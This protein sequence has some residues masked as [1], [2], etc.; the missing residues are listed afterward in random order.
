MA[1]APIPDAFWKANSHHAFATELHFHKKEPLDEA[2]LEPASP[3]LPKM[4]KTH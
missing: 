4:G 1:G 2:G 3:C